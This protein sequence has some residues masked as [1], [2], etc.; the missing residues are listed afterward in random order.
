MDNARSD[1]QV[2]TR[3]LPQRHICRGRYH[4]SLFQIAFPTQFGTFRTA[5]VVDDIQCQQI[6]PLL[7]VAYHQR[8]IYQVFNRIGVGYRNQ[9]LLRFH[10][11]VFFQMRLLHGNL[12]CGTLRNERAH[13]ASYKNQQDGTIQNIIVQ[14][15][16][17]IGQN[18]VVPHQHSRQ[19]C[20]CLCIAQSVHQLPFNPSHFIY[21]LRQPA[22]N[23]FTCQCHHN[24]YSRYFQSI[25]MTENHVHIN[26]HTHTY[27]EIGNKQGVAHKLQMVHQRRDMR[28]QP[29]QYQTC[30]ESTQDTFH[31]H[32][33]HQSGSEKNHGKHEYELHHVVIVPPE[34]PTA[35]AWKQIYNQDTQE[36]NLYDKPYPEEAVR[37]PLE[38]TTHNG[39]NQ[40]S[41][42][43]CNRRPPHCNAHTTM[44]RH[45]VTN[46]DGIGHQRMR[47]I[48][49]CQ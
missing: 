11:A 14:Q 29:V 15:A 16:F 32:K 45:T 24:H 19:R 47:R 5:I 28:N 10:G 39:Q 6:I 27:Q 2:V 48:H 35:Y 8:K 17:P 7:R 22:G 13:N 40:Q 26:Q 31:P 3:D 9:Y 25:A 21:F 38:H 18:D 44:P 46:H 1:I 41:E 20:R 34:E 23:P 49:T 42:C 43:I 30:K 12:P 37:L 4:G 36:D 33:L